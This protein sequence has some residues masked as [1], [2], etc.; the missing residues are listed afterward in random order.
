MARSMALRASNSVSRRALR[1]SALCLSC[2]AIALVVAE[3]L[4]GPLGLPQGLAVMGG[5]GLGLCATLLSV[6]L[7]SLGRT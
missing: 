3:W 4:S 2:L 1:M 6:V 7:L 5:V